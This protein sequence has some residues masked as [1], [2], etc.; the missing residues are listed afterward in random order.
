M[1]DEYADYSPENAMKSA[2]QI[3]LW[4]MNTWSAASLNILYAVQ[5]P[6]WS[7]NTVAGQRGYS[8]YYFVQ[9]PLWS[10]NTI[11]K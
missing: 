3:P 10:M 5:I 9:I 7:M 8:K 2:V 4:S 1:V 6:L 11:T